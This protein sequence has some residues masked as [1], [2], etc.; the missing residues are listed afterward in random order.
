VRQAQRDC[1]ATAVEPTTLTAIYETVLLS[2][3]K[4]LRK[5][6]DAPIAPGDLQALL[7]WTANLWCAVPGAEGTT[8]PAPAPP[9]IW[10]HWADVRRIVNSAIEHGEEAPSVHM[11]R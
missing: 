1:E 5:F 4:D 8:L 11:R 6:R 7:Q 2:H 3:R 10:L 9:T